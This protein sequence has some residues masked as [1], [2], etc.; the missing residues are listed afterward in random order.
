MGTNTQRRANRV[1]QAKSPITTEL[2]L[3]SGQCPMNTAKIKVHVGWRDVLA[4]QTNTDQGMW[5][6]VYG[7]FFIE[8]ERY[9]VRKMKDNK[10]PWIKPT[11][12]LFPAPL[13]SPLEFLCSHSFFSHFLCVHTTPWHSCISRRPCWTTVLASMD[14]SVLSFSSLSHNQRPPMLLWESSS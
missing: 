3:V 9:G 5:S 8:I 2:V 7:R 1:E 10:K 13:F 14:N 6:L 11:G 12:V 4:C